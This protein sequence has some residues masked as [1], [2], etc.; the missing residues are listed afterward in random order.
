M[1]A[2]WALTTSG[3]LKTKTLE[4]FITT[5][6]DSAEKVIWTRH[7]SLL[8]TLRCKRARYGYGS[9]HYFN[10]EKYLMM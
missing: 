4:L 9:A 7:Y 2:R 6:Y 8:I 3:T 5:V 1:S 10:G